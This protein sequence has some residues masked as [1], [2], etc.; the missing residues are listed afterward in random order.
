M[1]FKIILTTIFLLFSVI[2]LQAQQK[3]N[4]SSFPLHIIQRNEA[5]P[6]VFFLTGD[7]GWNKFSQNLAQMLSAHGYA[8]VALD[9]R[10][11][12]WEQKTPAQFGNDAGMIIQYYLKTW[13]KSSFVVLGYSFGA[14]VGAFL[15]TNLSESTISRL[16]S[17]VLL[18]PGFST[19]FVTK[20]SNML[21]MGDTNK[22][23]YKV[24][25]ALMKSPVSV[26]CI[27]GQDEESDFYDA[28]KPTVKIHKTKVPGSHRYDDNVK[29]LAKT[30]IQGF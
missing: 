18:S 30:I 21:G 5:K 24:Y 20:L 15:P 23:K 3:I 13:N 27:F 9:T 28:I 1:K 29:E 17:M 25:P 8:V 12:F 4:L 7:G 16:E 26:L 14:D 11:Y 22:E 19:G 2:E 6:L 10:N